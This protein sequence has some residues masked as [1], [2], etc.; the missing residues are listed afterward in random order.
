MIVVGRCF[1]RYKYNNKLVGSYNSST[2]SPLGKTP[3]R[4]FYSCR[5]AEQKRAYAQTVVARARGFCWEQ[6]RGRGGGGF[7]YS[8][9]TIDTVYVPYLDPR[10]LYRFYL[11]C[12]RVVG[13]VLASH[14]RE[15]S[16]PCWI[17]VFEVSLSVVRQ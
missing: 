7:I 10:P 4:V 2:I 13:P 8:T 16:S 5:H 14:K 3:A 9:A 1:F 17:L 15:T 11:H 6:K 12:I